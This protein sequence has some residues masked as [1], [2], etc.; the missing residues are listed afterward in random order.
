MSTILIA[1]DEEDLRR[2]LAEMLEQHSQIDVP[3]TAWRGCQQMVDG[4][5]AIKISD[6]IGGRSGVRPDRAGEQ[7]RVQSK[8]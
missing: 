6:G 8:P 3:R 4:A 5:A 7:R 2:E 1:E